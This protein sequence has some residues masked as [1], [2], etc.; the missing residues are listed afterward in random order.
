MCGG[1]GEETGGT[2]R[3][4]VTPQPAATPPPTG[5]RGRVLPTVQ[6]VRGGR[7]ALRR[8]QRLRHAAD[9]NS[10]AARP[11]PMDALSRRSS[12]ARERGADESPP[13][14]PA[15]D[16]GGGGGGGEV[17]MTPVQWS[18]GGGGGGGCTRRRITYTFITC[19][20]HKHRYRNSTHGP[21]RMVL[22]RPD[23]TVEI[24]H[25]VVAQGAE[26]LEYKKQD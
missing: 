1:G 24:N 20:M 8:R 14:A 7:G 13:M 11:A 10:T 6:E 26:H 5:L 25:T 18:V 9:G 15:H 2:D 12:R 19:T 23:L 3:L 4:P 17:C 21:Q 22:Y 16:T